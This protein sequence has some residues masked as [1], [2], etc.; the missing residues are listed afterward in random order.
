V[1][2]SHRH[3]C[4]R[5]VSRRHQSLRNRH[6]ACPARR[7]AAGA[8]PTAREG[9]LVRDRRCRPSLGGQRPNHLDHAAVVGRRGEL[10]HAAVV[11]RRGELG[12]LGKLLVAP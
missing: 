4:R 5:P 10:G 1:E 3:P 8:L 9:V 6:S 2:S 11:G 12:K 7:S